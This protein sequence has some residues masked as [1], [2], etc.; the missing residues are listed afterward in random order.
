MNLVMRSMVAI[1][2]GMLLMTCTDASAQALA[3]PDIPKDVPIVDQTKTL[4][5]EQIA[6]L[7]KLIQQERSSSGNQ[8][9]VVIIPSL[10]DESLEDY[11]LEVARKWG[12]GT[13]EN[14][15]GVLLLIAKDDRKFRIEVGTG[16]EG[17]LT[18]VQ[19]SRVLR[20]EMTPKFKDGKYYEGIE[21]GLKGI[22]NAIKGEYKATAAQESSETSI[23]WAAI[24]GF[25]FIAVSWVGSML[26]R[27]KSWWA[28]GVMGGVAG[29]IVGVIASS[30]LF[31]IIGF[32]ALGLSG[33]LLDRLVSRNYSSRV[34][35]G[36]KP[37]WWAGG[38]VIGGKPDGGFGGFGGGGFGGGG[39]SGDW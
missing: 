3:V 24:L 19:A 15:N 18:D 35:R 2:M 14:N 27:T 39:A 28:G 8:L 16:L 25:G 30:I 29:V 36:D 11:S 23:P 12:I 33:L 38:G 17:A 22:I 5:P 4:T 20:N 37:S 1:G 26:A 13:K 7:S 32:L 6:A 34:S 10:Q 9:G 31:G 21:A